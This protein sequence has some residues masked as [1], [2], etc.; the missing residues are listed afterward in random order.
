MFEDLLRRWDGEHVVTRYDTESGTWML[1]C[2]HS[3][4]LGPAMGGTRV[5]AYASPG[6][7]L[8]DGLRRLPRHPRALASRR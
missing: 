3:T 8:E 2:I 5:R 4:K 7:A 1:V 6:D